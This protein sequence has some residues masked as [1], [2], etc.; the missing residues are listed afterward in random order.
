MMSF[1]F[2]PL[3]RILTRMAVTGAAILSVTCAWADTVDIRRADNAVWVNGGSSYMD[4]R[5]HG[6]GST[7]DSDKGW[8]PT[9]AVGTSLLASDRAAPVLRNLYLR[10]EGQVSMGNTAYDGTGCTM[11]LCNSTSTS[12]DD[13]LYAL[14]LQMGRAFTL[15]RQIMLIPFVQIE[16]RHWNRDT[17]NGGISETLT[18]GSVQGGLT[19]QYSPTSRWVLGVTASGGTTLDS[20]MTTGGQTYALG[21][22]AIWQVQGKAGYLLTD[23]LEVTGGA[24]YQVFSAGA[25]AADS[26]GYAQAGSDTGRITVLVGASY[27]FF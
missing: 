14:D 25:S 27:H 22:A 11:H 18:N 12:S 6:A 16:Y 20:A 8:L 13:R 17:L 1:R 21:Q 4:Y 3:R 19:A 2:R 5:E 10:A 15:P 23:R 7:Q 9:V 24:G 26:R